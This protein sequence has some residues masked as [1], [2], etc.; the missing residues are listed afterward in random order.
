MA[1]SSDLF[2]GYWQ[3][4]PRLWTAI[5]HF[6]TALASYTHP[7]HWPERITSETIQTLLAHSRTE[8]H[9]SE[10]LLETHKL[11]GSFLS[12]FEDLKRRLPL[13]DAKILQKLFLYVGAALNHQKIIKVLSKNERQALKTQLGEDVYRFGIK[14]APLMI[15][16]Q[17]SW[18]PTD[19]PTQEIFESVLSSAIAVFE[20]I[21]S[22]AEYGI[23][24][25]IELKLPAA[26][27]WTWPQ[28][29]PK[30]QSDRAFQFVQRLLKKLFHPQEISFAL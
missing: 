16:N 29:I 8:G 27:T 21:F 25:R 6:N 4:N 19:N 10:W 30:E 20:M 3:E 12:D 2:L 11:Q 18:M 14:E 9:L 17:A 26:L 13:L 22:E 5:Y 1:L 24:K 28:D 7:S 23:K 15:G